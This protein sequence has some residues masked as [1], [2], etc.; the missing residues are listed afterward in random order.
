MTMLNNKTHSDEPRELAKVALRL[1][2]ELA[3][4]PTDD[5]VLHKVELDRKVRALDPVNQLQFLR[6]FT[7]FELATAKND[8]LDLERRNLKDSPEWINQKATVDRAQAK[9]NMI[10]SREFQVTF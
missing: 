9:W 8:L 6:W 5:L 4:H 7:D 3:I 2:Q 1:H 10:L